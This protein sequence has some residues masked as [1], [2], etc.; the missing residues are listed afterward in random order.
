M[1]RCLA[2]MVIA[3]L[4]LTA[5]SLSAQ[6]PDTTETS[7]V[8]TPA[9]EDQP[10]SQVRSEFQ[11]LLRAQPFTV[12]Q[13]FRVDPGLMLNDQYLEPYPALATF[14]RQHP[15]IPRNP[16]YFVGTSVDTP[17]NQALQG[18]FIFAI[19]LTVVSVVIWLVKTLV[20]YRRWSRLSRV[21]TEV[22]SKLLDRFTA[23]EDLQAYFT[24]AAGQRFLE[25][26]PIPIDIQGAQTTPASKILW[27]LQL[28]LVLALG[29]AG[30]H[31]AVGNLTE[32]SAAD[33]LRV[34]GTIAMALGIGFIL[35]AGASFA[36]SKKLGLFSSHNEQRSQPS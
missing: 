34:V 6:T 16:A 36:L 28:G 2:K 8:T 21:Q 7:T 23:S 17:T 4:I 12:S 15:E 29:G 11:R 13:V 35:S 19:F 5:T 20:D 26:A 32:E 10:A 1:R 27:S 30:L 31:V 25:A 24:S 3:A 14:I 18:L 33:P 22:H 9:V